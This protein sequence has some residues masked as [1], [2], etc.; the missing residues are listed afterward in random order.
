MLLAWTLLEAE[1]IRN[2]LYSAFKP[3]LTSV[4]VFNSQESF[5][6]A[7][8]PMEISDEPKSSAGR[9]RPEELQVRKRQTI[10]EAEQKAGRL[11]GDVD[12]QIIYDDA[13]VEKLV[14]RHCSP[15]ARPY[16]CACLPVHN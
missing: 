7:G 8:S 13:A 5:T 16:Y 10:V 6:I 1:D 9:Q 12:R 3:N 15:H 4:H 2:I 11:G 14:D